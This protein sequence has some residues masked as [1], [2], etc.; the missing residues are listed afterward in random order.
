MSHR[1]ELKAIESRAAK[2]VY[3]RKH[4]LKIEARPDT[5]AR[6]RLRILDGSG[7][8]DEFTCSVENCPRILTGET[9]PDVRRWRFYET[10]S[11]SKP[12]LD[13]LNALSPKEQEK[14]R[15]GMAA[16][17]AQ[18]LKAAKHLQKGLYQVY[19]ETGLKSLR[20]IFAP[21]GKR[22]TILLAIHIYDKNTDKMPRQIVEL[23]LARLA[24]WKQRGETSSPNRP[25]RPSR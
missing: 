8:A 11:G 6:I 13:F 9:K 15:A 5:A 22:G 7:I 2:V 12:V 10:V 1:E 24:D 21:E 18:G 20:L 16:V 3:A 4:K 23:A 19:A 25:S 17:K 14:V